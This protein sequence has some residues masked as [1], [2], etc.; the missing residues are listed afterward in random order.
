MKQGRVNIKNRIME[1]DNRKQKQ[2]TRKQR[3][4]V[5]S[6]INRK[7]AS[8]K[9]DMDTIGNKI[10]KEISGRIKKQKQKIRKCKENK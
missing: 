2:K 4:K 6:R 9:N 3:K 5:R 1:R 8:E 7:V 10:R